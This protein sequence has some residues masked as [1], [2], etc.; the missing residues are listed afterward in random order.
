L[1]YRVFSRYFGLMPVRILCIG[2][3]NLRKEISM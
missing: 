1:L 3:Y 2:E